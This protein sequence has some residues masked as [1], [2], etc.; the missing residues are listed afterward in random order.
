MPRTGKISRT[1][2]IIATSAVAVVALLALLVLYLLAPVHSAQMTGTARF[3][4]T[5]TPKRYAETVLSLADHGVNG[6]SK[7]YEKAKEEALEAAEDAESREELYDVLDKAIKAAGGKHSGLLK[8]E[9]DKPE[10]P[11]LPEQKSKPKELTLPDDLEVE[12]EGGWAF[13]NVPPLAENTDREEYA[14]TLATELV[15]A[16]GTGVCS[17]I[18]DLRGT[19]GGDIVPILGGLSIFV[20]NGPAYYTVTRDREAS[21]MVSGTSVKGEDLVNEDVGKWESTVAVLVDDTTAFAGE[22]A[23]LAL[24]GLE[25]AQSFGEPTAGYT[26]THRVFNFPDGSQMVIAMSNAVDAEE[27]E[28]GDK[29][30]KPDE[31]HEDDPMKAAKAWIYETTGCGWIED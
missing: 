15:K 5:D 16:R 11:D 23:L 4:G 21:V 29:P 24:S 7:E 1:G 2:I 14:R 19:T 13:V 22:A 30:I 10:N 27:N 26:S 18:V 3:G 25:N 9:D 31:I 17:A 12:I 8:P 28:Y 6:D 20:P